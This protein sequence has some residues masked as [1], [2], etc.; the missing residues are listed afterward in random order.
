MKTY[1]AKTE[2]FAFG[3]TLNFPKWDRYIELQLPFVSLVIQFATP[4]GQLTPTGKGS[5]IW[6]DPERIKDRLTPFEAD[7]Q[8]LGEL[9]DCQFV[10]VLFRVDGKNVRR[11][12]DWLRDLKA[13]AT[14]SMS[15]GNR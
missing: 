12:A 8:A 15:G 1:F 5:S 13:L 4:L 7:L 9:E 2:A 14:E 11:P 3:F 10:D 6:S